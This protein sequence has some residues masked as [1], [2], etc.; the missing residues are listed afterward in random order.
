MNLG[1]KERQLRNSDLLMTYM[2]VGGGLIISSIVFLIEIIIEKMK[3]RKKPRRHHHPNLHRPPTKVLDLHSHNLDA[4]LKKFVTPP[5]AYNSL[6]NP[7]MSVN[8]NGYKKKN[9]NG[10]E[11]WVSTDHGHSTLIPYRTPSALLFQFTN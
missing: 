2:I 1:N 6:F 8:N 4:G 11:Y 5:P 10:R 3:Q 7:P 9:I